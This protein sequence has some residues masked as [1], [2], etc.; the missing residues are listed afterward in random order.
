VKPYPVLKLRADG[1]GYKPGMGYHGRATHEYVILLEKGRRKFNYN[2]VDTFAVPWRGDAETKPHTPN[3]AAYPTA[4]PWM[5][6]REL[7]ELSSDE[8]E[9]VLDPFC[10]GGST[11]YAALLSGRRAIGIDKSEYSMTTTLSRLNSID[12]ASASDRLGE[13]A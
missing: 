12:A 2:F 1:L 13:A 9:V 11:I 3:R 6:M 8:G 10:G 4:K 7:I 5:L